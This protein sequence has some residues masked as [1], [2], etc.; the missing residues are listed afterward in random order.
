MELSFPTQKHLQQLQKAL[1]AEYDWEKEEAVAATQK[2]PLHVLQETGKCLFPV[3]VKRTE[4]NRAEYLVIEIEKNPLQQ[5]QSHLFGTGKKVRVFSKNTNEELFADGTIS[6]AGQQTITVTTRL[7]DEPEWID[8]G[9][10]GLYLL[11]DDFTYREALKALDTLQ[12]K[13]PKHTIQLLEMLYGDTEVKDNANGSGTDD[14]TTLNEVQNKAVNDI[15]KAEKLFVLHGPPGTGKSTTLAHA[16]Q[17]TLKR[18]K[19]VLYCAPSN[20]AVDVMTEKLMEMGVEVLRIGNPVK[21]SPSTLHAS[22]EYRFTHHEQF[23]LMKELRKKSDELHTMAGKYKRTFGHE[24]REHRKL[25][26]SEA[27]KMSRE[28]YEMEE[29]IERY[30]VDSAQV[31]CCTPAMS[32]DGLLE[33]REFPVLFFDEATQATE[34]IFWIPALKAKKVIMA[35]DHLQLGPTV[36]SDT[37]K[38]LGLEHSVFEKAIQRGLKGVMLQEQYRMHE[39]IMRFPAQ[40][41]YANALSAHASVAQRTLGSKTG[42]DQPFLFIDTAGSG[43]S[44]EQDEKSLS[45]RNPEEA[46]FVINF[47]NLLLDQVGQHHSVGIITPYSAQVKYF[48]ELVDAEKGIQISTVDGFQGQEKDIIIISCVRSNETGEI[49]FLQDTRRMNVALTR[50][51]KKLVVVG[52]SAT[53]G[54]HAFYQ[55]LLSYA[56]EVEG[57]TTIW[58]FTF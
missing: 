19:Q 55:D 56:E 20:T 10:I 53:L 31:I 48:Q 29:Q 11:H 36:K 32:N 42:F 18:E 1:Q 40:K 14:I 52:D 17:Q 22:L 49:G 39:K 44:E 34:P 57:Y 8:K 9:K 7:D 43:Y 51:R 47:L 54:S 50:A 15:L 21:I 30:L 6:K 58:E 45:I 2:I 35:G 5:A 23:R 41:F 33:S 24:E 16:I 4:Y 28:V 3:M 27:K 46:Q 12:H 13:P 25:M 37:A 26:Y 38:K